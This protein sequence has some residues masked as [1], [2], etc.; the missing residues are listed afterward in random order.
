VVPR[1]VEAV[2]RRLDAPRG[3]WPETVVFPLD[4]I[5]G[6]YTRNADHYPVVV[7][8]AFQSG[9]DHPIGPCNASG[10]VLITP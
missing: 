7:I 1:A 9:H 10:S 8:A 4:R 5:S 2:V 6:T 3:A